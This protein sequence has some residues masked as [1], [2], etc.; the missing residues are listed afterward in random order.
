MA[1]NAESER[2]AVKTN[3]FHDDSKAKPFLIG[4]GGGTA[5]GKVC[6]CCAGLYDISKFLM[7]MRWEPKTQ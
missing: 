5:S 2:T 6:R 7:A 4:V 1:S 3:G